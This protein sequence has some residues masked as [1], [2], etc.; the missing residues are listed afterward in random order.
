MRPGSVSLQLPLVQ[1]LLSGKTGHDA[2]LQNIAVK[3]PDSKE[4]KD[5]TTWRVGPALGFQTLH[6]SP[7]CLGSPHMHVFTF[8]YFRLL[9]AMPMAY[10]SSQDR[11]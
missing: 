8:I 4:N 9:G 6:L 2:Q 5:Q 3:L 10:G 11:G 1:S 7:G